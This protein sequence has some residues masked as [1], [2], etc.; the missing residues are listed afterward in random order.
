MLSE[1]DLPVG[2]QGHLLAESDCG[3]LQLPRN[4]RGRRGGG[5]QG[6]SVEQTPFTPL[7]GRGPQPAASQ[8]HVYNFILNVAF[9]CVHTW[10]VLRL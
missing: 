4:Q 10:S 3:R 5:E 2:L 6:G 1:H 7:C 8:L 9:K